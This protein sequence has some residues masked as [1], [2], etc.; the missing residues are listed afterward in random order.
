[1]KLVHW[2]LMGGPLRL[3]Q[4]GGALAGCGA[5]PSPLIAVPNVTI[6]SSTPSVP[7]TALF[8]NGLLFCGFNMPTKGLTGSRRD[9][10][11]CPDNIEDTTPQVPFP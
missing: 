5:P 1:M 8:Y 3:V 2:A 7:I 10:G 4:R 9:A 6:H 11:A